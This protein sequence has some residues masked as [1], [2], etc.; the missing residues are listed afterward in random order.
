[1]N[2]IKI[3]TQILSDIAKYLKTRET[4]DIIDRD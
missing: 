3:D 2:E 4:F 1:M